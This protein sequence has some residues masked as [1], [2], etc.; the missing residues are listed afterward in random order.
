MKTPKDQ[1]SASFRVESVQLDHEVP[2]VCKEPKAFRVSLGLQDWPA[3]SDP[4]ACQG[5]PDRLVVMDQLEK[6]YV[7]IG[8]Q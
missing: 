8:M 6:M 3:Q 5:N 7:I 2:W 1:Q 4:Q